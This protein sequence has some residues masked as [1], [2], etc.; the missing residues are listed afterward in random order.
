MIMK[1]VK[2]PSE[3]EVAIHHAACY[4]ANHAPDD[5]DRMIEAAVAKFRE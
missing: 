2:L 5:C 4:V 3:V 1:Q